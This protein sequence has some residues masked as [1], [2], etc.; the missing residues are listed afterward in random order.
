AV[1]KPE[2]ATIELS[3]ATAGDSVVM[4]VRDDGRG[5]HRNAIV[6]RAKSMG[7]EIPETIDNDAILKILCSSGFSTRDDADLTSGRGVGMSVVYNTIRE[8]GGSLTL[9]S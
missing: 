4:S 1:S 6:Q 2:E 3:A 5:I 8:L 7:L 9:H